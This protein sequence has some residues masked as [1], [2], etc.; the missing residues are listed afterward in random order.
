MILQKASKLFCALFLLICLSWTAIAQQDTVVVYE[1]QIIYDTLYVYDTIRV[2]TLVSH[3]PMIS[4]LQPAR[5]SLIRFLTEE[6]YRNKTIFRKLPVH[7]F[8]PINKL[9]YYTQYTLRQGTHF[10]YTRS[11]TNP[12]KDIIVPECKDARMKMKSDKPTFT[13]LPDFGKSLEF[14]LQAGLGIWQAKSINS[15]LRSRYVATQML[16]VYAAY[17]LTENL[18]LRLELN[19]SWLYRN[20]SLFRYQDVITDDAQILRPSLFDSTDLGS[21][22]RW[23]INGV[24]DSS[25][26]FS[27]FMVP[28]KLGYTINRF[29]PYVGAAM[30]YRLIKHKPNLIV[31]NVNAG[32][33]IVL[34]EKTSVAINFSR[35][36]KKELHRSGGFNGT[37]DGNIVTLLDNTQIVM[38]GSYDRFI[39]KNSGTCKSSN[40]EV[41]FCYHFSRKKNI[42]L[43]NFNP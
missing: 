18:D 11:V 20:G 24:G 7:I 4:G 10:L 32:L 40:L 43:K 13:V 39:E 2:N 9:P 35:S 3:S 12:E 28:V 38:P 31:W 30:V 26:S 25:Y 6:V 15:S 22:M 1:T 34:S 23:D 42:R 36:L 17:P 16:G 37:Y 8:H 5:D 27:Q 33:N 21:I 19:Y 41:I 29:Q 14:G